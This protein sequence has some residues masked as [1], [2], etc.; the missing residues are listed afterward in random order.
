MG[1]GEGYG[2]FAIEDS[3]VEVGGSSSCFINLSPYPLVLLLGE[4]GSDR[5]ELSPRQSI[6]HRFEA[7]SVNV[8]VRIAA[9]ADNSI[10]KGMDTRIFPAATH[11]DVYFIYPVRDG[12]QGSV[13]MRL[14]R[15]HQ[16]AAVRAYQ[17][18]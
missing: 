4:E 9:F 10:R 17:Q 11:R 15:E 7:G 3:P 18:D 16:N 1:G 6:V 12:E 2:V 5:V 8:R 14:L 13:R